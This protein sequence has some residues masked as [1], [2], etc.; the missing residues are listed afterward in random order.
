MDLLDIKKLIISPT[1]EAM[2]MGGSSADAQIL[3]TGFLESRYE[4]LRQVHGPALS[5][6]QIEPAT[7]TDIKTWLSNAFNAGL[8]ERVLSA[9]YLSILPPDD[10]L[11]WNLRY[12]VAI[13]RL[14][15]YRCK[16]ALPPPTDAEGIAQCHKVCYN[17]RFGKAD[18]VVNAKLIQ[19]LMDKGLQP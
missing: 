8:R 10:A 16:M 13:C 17:T 1:L 7:H 3:F 5:W 11:I 18:P 6:F 14:V 4:H 15:Y 2:G 19:A 9:C 12:A